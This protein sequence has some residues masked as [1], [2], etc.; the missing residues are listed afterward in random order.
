MA[1]LGEIEPS[2]VRYPAIDAPNFRRKVEELLE[3]WTA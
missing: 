1:A 2:L 3:K